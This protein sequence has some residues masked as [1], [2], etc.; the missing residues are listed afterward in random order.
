MYFNLI[1]HRTTPTYNNETIIHNNPHNHTRPTHS[2]TYLNNTTH[3][4]STYQHEAITSRS[5]QLL[6]MGTWL[7]E[8]C[9][10]TSRRQINNTKVTSSWFF[11]S[12]LNYDSRPTT[13]QIPLSISIPWSSPETAGTNILSHKTSRLPFPYSCPRH[14]TAW[15]PELLQ[16]FVK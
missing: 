5:R 9:W 10:A 16:F 8:S 7:P 13:H 6:M 1:T 14:F 2:E 3:C 4:Y 11:L 12:T 15:P